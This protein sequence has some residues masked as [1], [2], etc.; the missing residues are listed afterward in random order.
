VIQYGNYTPVLDS[1]ICTC[2]RQLYQSVL[3]MRPLESLKKN[4]ETTSKK[5]MITGL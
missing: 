2:I 1:S 3:P 5:I 4:A